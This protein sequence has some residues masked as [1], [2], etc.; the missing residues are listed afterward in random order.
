MDETLVHMLQISPTIHHELNMNIADYTLD[1]RWNIPDYFKAKFPQ[2]FDKVTKV[3]I[4]IIQ[5]EN[6]LNWNTA[7]DGNLTAKLAFQHKNH[8]SITFNWCKLIWS[9]TIPPTRTFVLWRFF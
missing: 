3:S 4:P 7:I 9:R 8:S 5:T 6:S 1:G 2:F